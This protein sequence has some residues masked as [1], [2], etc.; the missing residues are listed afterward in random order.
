MNKNRGFFGSNWPLLLGVIIIG[1][2]ARL[3]LM[4]LGH[5]YDLDSYTIVAE[6]IGRGGNVYADTA[7]YNYAPLWFN[8]LHGLSQ[9]A[10]HD[11]NTFHYLVTGFLSLVDLGIFY[12]LW[13]TLGKLAAC[14][15]FLNPISI[16]ITGFHCQFDNLAVLLGLWGAGLMGNDFDQP[17]NRR[18]LAGLLVLGLSLIA[19]HLLFAFPF[20]LA[21]KQKGLWQKCIIIVV[22]MACFLLSFVPYWHEGK[23]GIIHNVFLYRSSST[24]FFYKYMVPAVFQ[25]FCSSQTIWYL[26]LGL[27]AFIY[28]KKNA[29]ESLLFYTAVLVAASPAT[30]NQ[31]LAIPVSFVST[32]VNLF[33]VLYT[34][35]GTWHLT[36]Y[37]DLPPALKSSQGYADISIFMLSFA[38]AWITWRQ[39]WIDLYKR[40]REEIKIQ[41]GS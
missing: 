4:T 39:N 41:F 28:R 12:F 19:K 6:I 26:M 25:F 18:K 7:R 11:Q 32:Y 30:A 29:V 22:P 17:V 1:L 14:L 2:A 20:W 24:E 27:F 13:R 31:Y 3:F 5:T 8:I 16:I 37:F 40:C 21:I 23:Q 15:F 38:L 33:T 36:T 34:V 9:L 35:F 10:G